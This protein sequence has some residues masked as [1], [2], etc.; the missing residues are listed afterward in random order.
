MYKFPIIVFEGIEGSGKSFHINNI[1]K[2]L[3]K[4]KIKFIKFREPGG[5]KNS[6]K[7][8][9]LI[10]NKSSNYKNLTDLLM[11]MAARNENFHSI[12]KKYY[13]KKVILIDRFV[14][15]TLAYQ[16]YG[17]GLD[18]KLI[19]YLNRVILKNIKPNFTFLNIVN[20]KNL[21]YRI[22]NRRKNRYD[23]FN[24]KFYNKVQKGFIKLSKNKK[25]YMI[26]NSNLNILENKKKIINKINSLLSI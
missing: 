4:K 21:K 20:M 25:N 15:S 9:N 8:R 6:E 11:Y 16:H 7:I 26:I 13:K 18:K 24:I 17:M 19:V 10:L 5:S 2:H 22:N 1:Q 12:I 3:K 23:L 14:D